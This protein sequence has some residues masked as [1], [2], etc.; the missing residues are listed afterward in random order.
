MLLLRNLR[1]TQH[2]L[3]HQFLSRRQCST[4]NG[5]GGK[6]ESLLDK[7]KKFG[8]PVLVVSAVASAAMAGLAYYQVLRTTL[9]HV[10]DDVDSFLMWTEVLP[11]VIDNSTLDAGLLPSADKY[12]TRSSL[13]EI[14]RR[15]ETSSPNGRYTIVYGPKGVGKSSLV[16]HVAGTRKGVVRVSVNSSH[17][18]VSLA[19]HVVRRLLGPRAASQAFVDI[20]KLVS[21]VRAAT[22]EP[23]TIIFDMERG[24]TEEKDECLAAVRSLV[25]DLATCS[26][27]LIVLSDASEVVEFGR[28]PRENF[29][30]VG[31]LTLSEAREL[32]RKRK[33][34]LSNEV[35]TEVFNKIGTSPGGAGESDGTP[36]NRCDI[37]DVHC[38]AAFDSRS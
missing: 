14:I 21:T 27:C 2:N 25:K 31:E 32:L 35:M 22:A 26:K 38:S 1:R 7:L 23:V 36:G 11:S 13:E 10:K 20:P 5:A 33:C 9:P 18:K 6:A 8:P 30:F 4:T 24:P 29:V 19:R 16:H 28:D 37:P 15:A 17:D 34:K 12:V 3:V